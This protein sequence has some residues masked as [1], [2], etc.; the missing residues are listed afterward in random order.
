M[1][2]PNAKEHTDLK[3]D[4]AK[5][6]T[7]SIDSLL[8]ANFDRVDSARRQIN[9]GEV[10]VTARESRGT[11]S[12]SLIDR[13]AMAYL[14]P[15][16]FTDLVE[17]LPGYVSK[18]P[19]MGEANLIR[20]RQATQNSNDDYNTSSLGTAFVVDGVP[21]SSAAEMQATGDAD[22]QNRLSTGKG[23]DMRQLSTDD[24][25]SVEIV[26][27]IPSAEYGDLTSGLVKIKRKSGVTGL[28]ARFKADMQSQL[29]YIGKGFEM[30]AP[31]WTVNVSADYLDSRID[32][33]DNRDNFK[34]VTFSTR[35]N[36]RRA[37]GG[38]QLT[39]D[40]SINYTG[41]FERDKNDPDLTVNNTIDYYTNS[42][43][44]FSLN[45]AVALTHPAGGLFRSA[46]F[47]SGIGY[48]T[49]HL[50]Q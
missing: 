2:Y 7:D 5:R 27:G 30:P 3:F 37:V 50:H 6:H 45:N 12:A 20:L 42:I 41:T 34:R 22:R 47:T 18:D 13:Q 44:R 21:L 11:T 49:E 28:E 26:R 10:V 8:L 43:N 23:V 39:W 36:L 29:F 16:S 25:E 19:A 1:V 15:S 9:L 46:S 33:R 40:A 31:G 4:A 32:P 17:L 14:Q 48:S 24:I 38:K 35:S